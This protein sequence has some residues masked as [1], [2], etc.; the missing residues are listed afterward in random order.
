MAS[1][2]ITIGPP[3]Q[4][5]ALIVGAGAVQNAWQPILRALRPILIEEL[6]AIV[7]EDPTPDMANAYLAK[8]VN[9]M[10][11]G[12]TNRVVSEGSES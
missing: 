1:N 9:L 12:H 8:L 7:K 3:S 11:W 5:V 2:K 10:R 4:S 6:T